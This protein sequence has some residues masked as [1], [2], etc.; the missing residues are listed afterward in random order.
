LP[1]AG[2]V[3]NVDVWY[4]AEIGSES[5]EPRKTYD[6]VDEWLP[7]SEKH[8]IPADENKLAECDCF[9]DLPI[10][11]EHGPYPV[12]VYIHGTA[13]FRTTSMAQVVHW[14][15]RGF[16]VIAADHLGMYMPDWLAGASSSDACEGSMPSNNSDFQ[17]FGME[18]D[19]LIELAQAAEGPLAFLEGK[20]DTVRSGATGH[21]AGGVATSGGVMHP[22]VEVAIPMQG[23]L[24]DISAPNIKSSLGIAALDDQIAVWPLLSTQFP[25]WSVS[26]QR[27]VGVS[28]A[29]HLM[30]TQLCGL[31]NDKG[32][33][34][35]D[36]GLEY[37]VCGVESIASLFDCS[38]AHIPEATQTEI[39]NYVTAA[40][41]EETLHCRDQ[42]EAFAQLQSRY[43]DVA[44][45]TDAP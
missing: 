10:D 22:T 30:V 16:I 27:L 20:A 23:W 29:G 43:P 31:D 41:F 19:N 14:A 25:L 44:E 33:N 18:A 38:D 1:E 42:T 36:V 6:F 32:K 5:G 3:L 39:V 40:A 37:G 11:Q 21:S 4:P 34:M 28:G 35:L 24:F 26:K 9:A 13:A 15:S 2:S 8:K 17:R 12:I 45:F 7:E